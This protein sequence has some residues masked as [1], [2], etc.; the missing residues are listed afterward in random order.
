MPS[1]IL[2]SY[3]ECA[4]H[5]LVRQCLSQIQD[6]WGAW[7]HQQSCIQMNCDPCWIYPG[8][9]QR[10]TDC[11]K[12]RTIVEFANPVSIPIVLG[13][14]ISQTKQAGPCSYHIWAI[15]TKSKESLLCCPGMLDQ[16]FTCRAVRRRPRAVS[17]EGPLV[18]QRHSH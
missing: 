2:K 3:R 8:K 14:T 9:Q 1:Q 18:A 17:H 10:F 13:F 5:T 4:Q 12:Y 6:H 16:S 11:H 15:P 7:E